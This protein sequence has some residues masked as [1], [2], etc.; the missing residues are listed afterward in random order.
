MN[1]VNCESYIELCPPTEFSFDEY[2]VFLGRSNLEVLHQIKEGSLY[3]LLSFNGDFI[4]IKISNCLGAIR[5]DF[6]LG[7]PSNSICE[8]VA[9]YI[10][11]WFDLNKDLSCF[12]ELAQ[13]D[14]VLKPLV[15][16]Y[17]GLRVIGI[18][19]LFEALTWAIMG[20]QINLTFAYTLKR[21]FVEQFG[22]KFEWEGASYWAYPSPQ[23]IAAIDINDLKKLQFTS[24]KSEYIIDL[25]KEMATGNLTKESII[26]K[27]DYEQRY[28]SLMSIRGVGAWTADYVMMK[29][30]NHSTAFPIADVGLHNAL[31]IQLELDRKPTIEEIEDMALNWS[32]WEAYATFYLWR[33]LL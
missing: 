27:N 20:Q 32:G 7:K 15:Q 33:S 26:R 12:Y 22:E 10:E 9:K 21:R 8:K 11:E 1:W 13:N 14:R 31:K 2:L 19:D 16:K 4:I 28:Q 17:Y 23:V 6:P 25:A 30:F 24:R 29:C 5:V 3:K 18:S